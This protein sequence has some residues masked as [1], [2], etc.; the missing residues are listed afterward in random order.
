MSSARCASLTVVEPQA[1]KEGGHA[2]DR[3]QHQ[4]LPLQRA[5]HEQ[6]ERQPARQEPCFIGSM[7]KRSTS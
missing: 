1:D 3:Y 6:V 5:Q 4:S 2:N 7:G